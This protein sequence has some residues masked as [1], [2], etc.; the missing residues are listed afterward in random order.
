MNEEVS[1]ICRICL[2][3]GSQNIFHNNRRN[4]DSISSLDRILE[5]LRFVTMLKIQPTDCLP[6]MICDSCLVQLNVAYNFKMKAIESDTKLHQYAIEKGFGIPDTSSYNLAITDTQHTCNFIVPEPI[7]QQRAISH[8]VIQASENISTA[9]AIQ[10]E[11]LRHFE[12]PQSMSSTTQR[13]SSQ[14]E[15]NSGLPPFRCMPILVKVEPQDDYMD[16]AEV[17]P[18]TSDEN[19]QT[20]SDSSSIRS[21]DN[22]SGSSMVC[23]NSKSSKHVKTIDSSSDKSFVKAYIGT[24]GN[25]PVNGIEVT[26]KS[27]SDKSSVKTNNSPDEKQKAVKKETSQK[28]T[29]RPLRSNQVEQESDDDNLPLKKRSKNK[30][31]ARE[32]EILQSSFNTV[33]LGS[34]GKKKQQS[35]KDRHSTDTSMTTKSGRKISFIV[36][37]K[38]KKPKSRSLPTEDRRRKEFKEKLKGNNSTSKNNKKTK[39]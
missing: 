5:K 39:T 14:N 8:T 16:S 18:A 32:S 20:V 19:L 33:K 4:V 35:N 27:S 12:T 22:L 9:A 13:T 15:K 23:V 7:H 10:Q 31:R 29:K 36:D 25:L 30:K 3:E 11:Y 17:S 37:L 38:A 21:N 2:A 26:T 6:G 24:T 34:S 28:S 1:K